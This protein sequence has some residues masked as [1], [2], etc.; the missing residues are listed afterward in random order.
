MNYKE[1]Q[2]LCS[3]SRQVIRYEL[4]SLTNIK[5]G[6]CYISERSGERLNTCRRY[7]LENSLSEQIY[8]MQAQSHD[9][10]QLYSVY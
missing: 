10:G 1:I 7:I 3:Y 2:L 8:R 9:D 5:K 4:S 6:K